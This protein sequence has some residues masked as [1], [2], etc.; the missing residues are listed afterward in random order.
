[1]EKIKHLRTV[2]IDIID[3][4]VFILSLLTRTRDAFSFMGDLDIFPYSAAEPFGIVVVKGFNLVP[5]PSGRI[6]AC[7]KISTYTIGYKY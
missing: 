3:I 5:F 2:A 6:I 7:I 1:L 4:D